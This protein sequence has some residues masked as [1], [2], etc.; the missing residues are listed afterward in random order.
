[1][2]FFKPGAFTRRH[3]RLPGQLWGDLRRVASLRGRGR[4]SPAL[5][6][7][8][9]LMVT[10]VNRCPYCASFHSYVS[11]LSGITDE[12]IALLLDGSAQSVPEEEAPALL[13][14]RLWA[15]A[16]G[17]PAAELRTQLV[18]RYGEAQAAAIERVLSTIWVGNLLGNTW[19]AILFRLSGGRLV[20]ERR[21]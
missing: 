9:M 5:R 18:E 6:Q 14:A 1:M 11:R 15:E 16:A 12:E 17:E 4:V 21:L 3:Y 19:D 7:R 10:S 13:Y 20:D 2:P 8:L